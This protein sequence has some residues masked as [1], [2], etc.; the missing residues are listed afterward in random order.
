[1]VKRLEI[2]RSMGVFSVIHAIWNLLNPYNFKAL[3]RKIYLDFTKLIY[4]EV[5]S[6]YYSDPTLASKNATK[7]VRI[8]IS[9]KR[10]ISFK[11]FYDSFFE[12]LD[13]NT[14]S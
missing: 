2:K 7:D 14:K 5:I 10:G 4:M 9:R 1:M 12:L 13:N 6:G 8:D 3:S 11:K